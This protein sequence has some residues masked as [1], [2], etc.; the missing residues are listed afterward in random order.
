MIPYV[1]NKVTR[2]VK[3]KRT[4][5]NIEQNINPIIK[6]TTTSEINIAYGKNE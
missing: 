2:S 5:I 3:T 6:K 4:G 1:K